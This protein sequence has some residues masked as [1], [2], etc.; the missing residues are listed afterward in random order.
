[1]FNPTDEPDT[2]DTSSDDYDNWDS[3]SAAEQENLPGGDGY[4]R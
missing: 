4:G 3:D 2:D 1:M